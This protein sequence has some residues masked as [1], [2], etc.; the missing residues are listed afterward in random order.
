MTPI[1]LAA[2]A[3]L[4]L[5]TCAAQAFD[6]AALYPQSL[7]STGDLSRV[8]QVMARAQ[9]GEKVT[10]AV[11]GG[12]ITQG[13]KATKPEQ[14]YGNL[15]A[16]WWRQAFPKAQVEFVNA[17]IGATGSNFG[18]LRA[19][20]D[21]L[22]HAPDFVVVEYGVNDG[23]TQ[24]F[25]ETLE[26]LVRQ[27]LKQPRQPA[28][29]QL[30][31]MHQGGGN[32]QEWHGKVGRHYSLPIA[33]YRDA[34]WP[35]IQA[36]RI[37]WSDVMADE[38]HPNDRGHACAAEYVAHL[39][40]VARA[41]CP[42]LGTGGTPAPQAKPLPPP[43]FSDLY[44]FTALFEAPDLKPVSNSGWTLDEKWKCWRAVK[45][46]SVITFEIDGT[47]LFSMHLVV[48]RPMGKAS[49]QVDG[50]K[51]SVLEG[52]FNQTWG[53]YRN[54]TLLAKDL[55][56]GKHTVRVELLEEKNPGSEGHEFV[57]YGLGAAGVSPK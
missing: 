15:V 42:C 47:A 33:S 57:L 17:G 44:E 10:V 27:I 7:V 29:V 32:A 22:A 41:T 20:R 54:T 43:L 24:A 12:S 16:D 9:R 5:M 34:L 8:W 6:N 30:F 3:A 13:A 45:P 14:R 11:I 21:L 31:M 52:W 37:A 38:V 56:P 39:L 50:G 23:N 53:G 46:G 35:E 51:P 40:D 55:K 36:G 25:A 19:K 1:R 28:V 49:V 26:G 48:K 2:C 18:A 4:T